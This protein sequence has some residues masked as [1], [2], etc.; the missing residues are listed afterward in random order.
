[1]KKTFFLTLLSLF[2]VLLSIFYSS[3]GVHVL[4]T[5][6]DSSDYVDLGKTINLKSA[7]QFSAEN[8]LE[9]GILNTTFKN[10]V[11][12]IQTSINSQDYI[13][14]SS[15]QAQTF[16]QTLSSNLSSY[17]GVSFP[18]NI[19]LFDISAE[20]GQS[21]A[22]NYHGYQNYFFYRQEYLVKKHKIEIPSYFTYLQQT[23]TYSPTYLS[24]LDMVVNGQI[25]AS[26]F[27][28]IFGTHMLVGGTYGGSYTS[29][30]SLVTNGF[31]IT[32]SVCSTMKAAVSASLIDSAISASWEFD[33]AV[34]SSINQ[35]GINIGSGYHGYALG[36]NFSIASGPQNYQEN[37]SG[38]YNS[39]QPGTYALILPSPEGLR[40]ISDLIP[41]TYSSAFKLSMSSAL[42]TYLGQHSND[43]SPFTF[44]LS[45]VDK[46][47]ANKFVPGNSSQTNIRS[48]VYN[49]AD[50]D[51]Y[52][53]DNDYFSLLQHIPQ[54][55]TNLYVYGF[56]Y[57]S[58]KITLDMKEIDAGYQ[59]I[60]I[61]N[62]NGVLL[63]KKDNIELS[64]GLLQTTYSTER[65]YIYN[66]PLNPSTPSY[67]YIRYGAHGNGAD[68]WCAKNLYFDVLFAK[69][70]ISL[71]SEINDCTQYWI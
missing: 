36:G 24:Y 5:N 26:D 63:W 29:D 1:M 12:P 42:D 8:F 64:G 52:D 66:L 53:S 2:G 32:N 65:Y 3:S 18:T 11:D 14:Y 54:T 20:F 70:T 27:F 37:T 30:Y 35:T 49:I 40:R 28:D 67:I 6:A 68:D 71:A 4:E 22:I 46:L 31:S 43:F 57:M 33:A 34:L 39:L 23:S 51:P 60:M 56:R 61:Y 25:S 58:F 50:T 17:T 38:W 15:N 69:T 62:D 47:R 44:N 7:S 16:S 45:S 9:K 55:M 48:A 10:S 21:L 13:E 59:E 41:S 19:A